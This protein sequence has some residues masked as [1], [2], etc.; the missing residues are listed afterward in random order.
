[1]FT[2]ILYSL[3]K[4]VS[5]HLRMTSNLDATFWNELISNNVSSTIREEIS[6][7]RFHMGISSEYCHVSSYQAGVHEHKFYHSAVRR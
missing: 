2:L 1:M 4:Q 7:L 5:Y 6:V 3:P